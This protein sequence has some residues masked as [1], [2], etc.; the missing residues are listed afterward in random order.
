MDK[1]TVPK[2]IAFIMD[3]NGRWAKARHMPRKYGHKNGVDAMKRVIC[4]CARMG[5][6]IISIYAFSTENWTR[7]QDEID[8]LFNLVKRFADKELTQYASDNYRVRFMGDLSALPQDVQNSLD[9]ITAAVKDN[10]G[11]IIN[12]GLNYG[13]RDEIVRAVNSLIDGGAKAVSASDIAAKLDTRDMC[14]P[15]VIVRSAGEKRLSNFMLWQAAYSEFIFIDDYWPDFTE[16]T[17]ERIVREYNG[18]E[19]RYGGLK[20]A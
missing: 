8:E 5:I 17:V 18:R 1:D 6:E 9:K 15:D 12:I 16:E 3:G 7:P 10:S 20:K 11:P 2:H 14:D 4:A 13:A 19:R